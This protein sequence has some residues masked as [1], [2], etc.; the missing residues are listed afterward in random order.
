[1]ITIS[2]LELLYRPSFPNDFTA[3]LRSSRGKC[4]DSGNP[5]PK[6]QR[7]IS[8]VLNG[9]V[10]DQLSRPVQPSSG[11]ELIMKVL[12]FLPRCDLQRHVEKGLSSAQF[13][14]ETVVSAKQCLQFAQF[15]QYQAVLV[16]SDYLIFADA[17]TLVRLLRQKSSDASLF[18]LARYLDLEQR[19]LL[20]EA[21]VDDCVCEPF[22]G[23]EIACATHKHANQ[24]IG[25]Q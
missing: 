13:V 10:E 9:K 5:I 19:L 14:V 4:R 12:T 3:P 17:L 15:A 1:M 25:G 16:D 24:T 11:L 20:F 22:F 21:G 8:S 18:V 6:L 23:S 2:T 7:H